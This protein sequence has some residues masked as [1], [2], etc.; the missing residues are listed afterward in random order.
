M[1]CPIAPKWIRCYVTLTG[2]FLSR[3]LSHFLPSTL[4][5]GLTIYW[6]KKDV[7]LESSVNRYLKSPILTTCRSSLRWNGFLHD[8]RGISTISKPVKFI[9]SGPPRVRSGEKEVVLAR[10]IHGIC[11][12]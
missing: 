12:M 5:A 1:H 9:I 6:L 3:K 8:D 4:I 2:M 11:F 7:N 10:I